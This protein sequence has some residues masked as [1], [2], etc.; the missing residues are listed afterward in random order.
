MWRSGGFLHEWLFTRDAIVLG[1]LSWQNDLLSLVPKQ[2]A[3]QIQIKRVFSHLSW[4]QSWNNYIIPVFIP[5]LLRNN[6][7]ALKS[8]KILAR[9]RIKLD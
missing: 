6:Q 4:F 8:A 9:E 5:I 1:H 2:P 3:L 7:N